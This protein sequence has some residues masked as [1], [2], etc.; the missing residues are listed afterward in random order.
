MADTQTEVSNL[1][2]LAHSLSVVDACLLAVERDPQ[3]W[4]HDV[5][6]MVRHRQPAGYLAIKTA[7]LIAMSRAELPGIL[8]GHDGMVCFDFPFDPSDC[9]PARSY[10]Q[11][12]ALFKWLKSKGY[13]TGRLVPDDGI[14]PGI[15]DKNHPRYSPKLAAAIAA[16]ESFDEAATNSGSVKQKLQAWLYEHAAEYPTPGKDSLSDN[17]IEEI[18][19]IANWD[20]EG[21]APK[22]KGA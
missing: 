9:D 22:K 16:W 14:A 6:R 1:W 4:S 17:A 21:G 15:I 7:I 18:S 13:P 11:Q 5:E 3:I 2:G 19:T 20:T 12:G 8:M 10:V